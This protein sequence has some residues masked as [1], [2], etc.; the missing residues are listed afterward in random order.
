MQLRLA[1]RIIADGRPALIVAEIGVNHD[2][3]LS[4]AMELVDA[5]AESGADAVKLQIFRAETLLH[6]SGAFAGYQR[7]RCADATP[8]DMLRRYELTPE[9]L[10]RII[11]AI[12]A[13]GLLPLATPF[14][15]ADV[16]LIERLDLPAVKIASPDL[17]NLP[18]LG[19][20]ARTGLPLLLSTGAATM[21][22]VAAT[23]AT[24]VGWGVA[25][26]LLHCV[27]SYP[28]PDEQA[29]L[30]WI[31]ELRR[32]FD[33]PI[34]YS[35][36]TTHEAAGALAVAAGACIVEKHLTYD[37]NAAGP[38]HASSADP[39]QFARYVKAIRQ[40]ERLKGAGPKRVL[41]IE[42]DVRLVGRQS[43]VTARALAAGEVIRE[44]DLTVQRP[45]TGISA[46][47]LAQVVG[48]SAVRDLPART[49]LQWEMLSRP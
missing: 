9:H 1:E 34:G 49:L 17:V 27:S 4:R 28:T 44:E 45:G 35:D 43:L 23:Y 16:A 13:R 19:R 38:D 47:A 39:E 22:E 26:A 6:A 31:G 20:A 2:G 33:V 25:F 32:R 48:R 18:L 29:N 24:L 8:A 37:R 46:A 3:R 40:A 14:S 41:D 10:H 11:Y 21:E 42:R 12:R 30:A 36:H 5:A 7:R 15:P